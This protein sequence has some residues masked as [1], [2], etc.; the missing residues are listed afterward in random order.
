[1]PTSKEGVERL[2]R[3]SVRRF[4]DRLPE[5]YALL[6]SAEA[7]GKKAWTDFKMEIVRGHSP[8]LSALKHQKQALD[9]FRAE[10]GL[11]RAPL[12]PGSKPLH[13]GIVAV[14]IVVEAVL[15]GAMLA[16][17]MENGLVGGW[18]VALGVAV[19]NVVFL[20]FGFG[21][22]FLRLLHGR[23]V[24]RKGVGIFGLGGIAIAIYCSNLIVAH[25]RDALGVDPDTAGTAALSV[26]RAAPFNP[27]SLK[28]VQSLWLLA[29]GIL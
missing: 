10:N 21:G 22:F 28:D 1:M 2:T 26:W 11:L 25:Y 12:V 15:N 29:L 23:Q 19:L 17:G 3:E 13:Y 14:L 4:L 24:W 6:D 27:F 9:Q 18:A 16:R 8:A 5:I 20:G 7:Y